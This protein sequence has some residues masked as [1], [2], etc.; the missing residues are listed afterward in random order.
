MTVQTSRYAA[1]ANSVN[2]DY[3][4]RSAANAYSRTLSQQR[5]DRQLGDTRRNFGRSLP[6]F[7]ASFGRRGLSGPGVQ[8]GVQTSA[9]Q[10][11]LG[12]YDR[13][14]GR[15]EDQVQE[16][17]QGFMLNQANLDSQRERALADIEA[18]K[19]NEIALTALN[20]K[21]LAPFIGGI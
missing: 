15:I 1:Q 13:G 9:L 21:A 18:S 16:Q 8:S 4:A 10:R 12:D 2:E 11:Y 3:G 14:M 17:Q 5:G 7:N 19:Q 20:L 6:K